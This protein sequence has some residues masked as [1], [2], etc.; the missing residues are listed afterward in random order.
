MSETTERTP[1]EH[2]LGQLLDQGRRL[3]RAGDAKGAA[4][5]YQVA[6]LRHPFQPDPWVGL[7]LCQKRLGDLRAADLAF[8]IADALGASHP[9]VLL[10]RAECRVREGKLDLA[11]RDLEQCIA[12]AAELD[13]ETTVERA[14]RTLEWIDRREVT[15]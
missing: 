15:P 6:C 1:E 9:G 12:R 3:A 10:H 5:V 2:S 8:S 13:E 4:R 14:A 7:G 11:R